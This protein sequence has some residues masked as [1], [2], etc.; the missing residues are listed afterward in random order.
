MCIVAAAGD[1]KMLWRKRRRLQSFQKHP[2]K[3]MHP[4]AFTIG[5]GVVVAAAA[6]AL[7]IS[8][9]WWASLNTDEAKLFQQL[10]TLDPAS[11]DYK[12][13]LDAFN[14][15]KGPET[16]LMVAIGVSGAIAGL[17]LLS[18]CVSGMVEG[19]VENGA[20]MASLN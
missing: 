16:S 2:D 1:E 11:A 4:F 20:R 15:L 8:I 3:I 6:L 9:G 13:A 5:S 17:G 14:A 10:A 12:A 7:A 18:L 19:G